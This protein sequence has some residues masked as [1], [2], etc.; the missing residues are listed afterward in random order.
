MCAKLC[1][2]LF[3]HPRFALMYTLMCPNLVTWNLG[4][5]LVIRIIASCYYYSMCKFQLCPFV[6][7]FT[8]ID[9]IPKTIIIIQVHKGFQSM[10]DD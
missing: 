8:P 7:T 3:S 6:Q 10:C 1:F 2:S 4:H 5:A 9:N